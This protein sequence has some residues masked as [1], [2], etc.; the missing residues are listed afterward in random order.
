VVRLE[1]EVANDGG[2]D[3]HLQR[4]YIDST[5]WINVTILKIFSK[6]GDF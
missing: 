5:P 6:N 3:G 1:V 2:E 4:T